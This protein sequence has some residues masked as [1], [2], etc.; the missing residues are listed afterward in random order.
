MWPVDQWRLKRQI[1]RARMQAVLA[2][3]LGK[4]ELAKRIQNVAESLPTWAQ[5]QDEAYLNIYGG[6]R[7]PN[8]YTENDLRDMQTKALNMAQRPGARA[9][10]GTL[11]N[12]VI[13]QECQYNCEDENP[14]VQ[15]YWDD[16]MDGSNW[17]MKDKESFRRYI[18]DGELFNRF[19]GARSRIPLPGRKYYHL[20]TRF[21]EPL[22]IWNWAGRPEANFGVETEPDDIETVLMYYR[23]WVDAKSI[24][25]TGTLTPEE[26][27]HFKIG[28][29][30]NMKRGITF[31]VG[32]AE[33][34]VKYEQWLDDRIKLNKIRTL[35]GLFGEVQNP[36]TDMT[37][38]AAK[39]NADTSGKTEAGG[40][41]PKKMLT[42]PQVLLTK[43]V[44]WEM[45]DMNIKAQDTKDDGRAIQLQIAAACQ[46][47]EYVVRADASNAN[48]AS[49]MVSESPM[50]KTFEAMRDIHS[51]YTD[52]VAARVIGYGIKTGQL[53]ATSTKTIA[54]DEA[55]KMRE[56]VRENKDVLDEID[57]GLCEKVIKSICEKVETVPTCT[58]IKREYPPLIHRDI[59]QET[60]ALTLQSV[61]GWISDR[62]ASAKLGL[63]YDYEKQIRKEDGDDDRKEAPDDGTKE[64]W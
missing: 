37:S 33:Y 56:V 31:L 23:E 62:T 58:R 22:E 4:M 24:S 44:K 9:I 54:T 60:E 53:P 14:E 18:R 27:L 1:E 52:L 48:Y 3:E 25:H 6:Q 47:A 16:W 19:F 55:R 41:T 8:N 11:E 61:N 40:G 13:G 34:I 2:E 35:Y 21:I 5:D 39:I 26:L 63:D 64:S 57:K 49:T 32:A 45:K 29:D 10:I 59:K 12:F 51:R 20:L 36:A 42:G 7:I 30:S 46:L 43:G 50:V 15:E 28:V 38:L 17:D